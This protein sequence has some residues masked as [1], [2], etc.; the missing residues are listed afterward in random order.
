MLQQS[1]KWPT[2]LVIMSVLDGDNFGFREQ[3]LGP[4]WDRNFVAVVHRGEAVPIKSATVRRDGLAVYCSDNRSNN[5]W[6]V[7]GG[8][9]MAWPCRWNRRGLY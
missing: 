3:A 1:R 5:V 4:R 8:E 6:L 9:R 2:Q 7:R